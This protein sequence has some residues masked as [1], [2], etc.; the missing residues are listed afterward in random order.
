M[1][2]EKDEVL[3]ETESGGVTP[4]QAE[5]ASVVVG[6]VN[7]GDDGTWSIVPG[8]PIKPP[9]M[10]ELDWTRQ[11]KSPDELG[12]GERKQGTVRTI[13]D[14]LDSGFTPDEFVKIAPG[15]L[16]EVIADYDIS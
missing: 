1:P 9:L 7:G 5:V 16:D 8:P 11:L 10:H 15:D 3:I 6:R 12:D 2:E 4:E 14:L 13:K